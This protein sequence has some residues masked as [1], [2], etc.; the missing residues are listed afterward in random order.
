MQGAA[1]WHTPWPPLTCVSSCSYDV[2]WV[3]PIFVLAKGLNIIY[4]Q[5]GVL[6]CTR[7][8]G[9]E[10]GA[11]QRHAPTLLPQDIADAVYL[12]DR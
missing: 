4:Y 11:H 2:L 9:E 3:Y 5:V 7:Q 12:L 8:R 1:L 10:V 6:A